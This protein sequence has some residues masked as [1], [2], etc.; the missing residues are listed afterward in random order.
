M[1]FVTFV[2]RL[3]EGAGIDQTDADF[4][5][6]VPAAIDFAEQ[7]I[8]REM[9]LLDT[10]IRDSSATLTAN[11]RTFNLP[12]DMGRFVAINGINVISPSTQTTPDLGTRNQL[13]LASRDS[14][15]A[16]WP[17]SAG[18]TVPSYYAMIT[19]QQIVVGPAP[20]AAYTVEVI[21]TI[22]PAPLSA[23]NPTT[24]LTLYLPDLFLAAGAVF[25]SGFIQ[26][27]ASGPPA[28]AM[29]P[30][31]EAEYTKLIGSANIEEE[32]K[33]FGSGAWGFTQP[34]TATLP[35]K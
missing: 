22:R 12:T 20:D 7:R 35:G 6:L 33:R 29:T 5:T 28:A 11:V 19:D 2:L 3:A 27:G 8:Y 23:S 4:T 17:S 31:L 34:A 9:N 16:I 26:N 13:T 14:I 21:G 24:Y 30:G 25:V 10:V 1:N 32:R 15:D 18:A